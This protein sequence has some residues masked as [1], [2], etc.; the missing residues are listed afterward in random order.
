MRLFFVAGV[1]LMSLV[2]LLATGIIKND[3][4][5]NY[6]GVFQYNIMII[7]GIMYLPM[8]GNKIKINSDDS[9][10]I[11]GLCL[12]LTLLGFSDMPSRKL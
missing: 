11:N 8:A 1:I 4:V 9:D 6:F 7:T 2:C 5:Q 12:S 3:L 10:F